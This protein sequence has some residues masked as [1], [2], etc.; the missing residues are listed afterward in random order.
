MFKVKYHPNGLPQRFKARLVAQGFSQQYGIDY[1]DTY[2]PTLRLDSL[3][4]LLALAAVHD[5]EV[6][7]M[8]IVGAYL[9]GEIEEELYMRVL[10]GIRALGKVC[11]LIKGLYGL[12]QAGRNWPK[13]IC[14]SLVQLGFQATSADPSMSYHPE[15]GLTIVLYVDDLLVAGQSLDNIAWVKIELGK[16]HQVKGLGEANICLGIQICRDRAARTL[17]ID[18]TAYIRTIL[19][20]FD[21]ENCRTVNTPAESNDAFISTAPDDEPADAHL[22][23]QA[24]GSLMWAMLGTWPDI[25][26]AIGRLSRCSA[27]PALRHWT[28]VQRVLR[29]LKATEQFH[30]RYDGQKGCAPVGFGDADYASDVDGRKSTGAYVFIAAGA[31]IAWVSKLQ[32]CIATSTTEAE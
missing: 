32:G 24:V 13:K 2:A 17:T 23:Q 1:K 20:R 14:E 3:R 12:K 27:A 6:H 19:P 8:D 30:L 21:L 9:E 15:K 16:R 31:P 25:A 4:L 18:Q 29:Y 10:E 7:Q 26:F 22:Y 11:R 5:H 28:A